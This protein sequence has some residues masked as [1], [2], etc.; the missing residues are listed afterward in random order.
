[1]VGALI[2]TVFVVFCCAI[3]V[4][5]GLLVRLGLDVR[6]E[7]RNLIS[8]ADGLTTEVKLAQAKLE[9]TQP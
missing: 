6:R 7:E 2:T 9:R 4:G 1:V 5:I 3:L 8:T